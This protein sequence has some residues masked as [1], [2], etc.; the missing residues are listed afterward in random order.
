MLNAETFGSPTNA[1]AFGAVASLQE[2]F[3]INLI[4]NFDFEDLVVSA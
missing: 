2:D 1:R 3:D 4:L